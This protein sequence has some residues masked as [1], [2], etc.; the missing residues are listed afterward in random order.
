MEVIEIKEATEL[1]TESMQIRQNLRLSLSNTL[2][3]SGK[4]L[5]QTDFRADKESIRMLQR[6]LDLMTSTVGLDHPLTCDIQCFLK[7]VKSR[8]CSS[9][10]H[11]GYEKQPSF[12]RYKSASNSKRFLNLTSP[13]FHHATKFHRTTI[14]D[15]LNSSSQKEDVLDDFLRYS[16][17]LEH[18]TQ[19]TPL[20]K[21]KLQCDLDEDGVLCDQE[22]GNSE[23]G[24]YSRSVPVSP[25]LK[26]TGKRPASVTGCI[27]S[28]LASRPASICQESMSGPLSSLES[29]LPFN[30]PVSSSDRY[31]FLHKSAWYHV[32][33]RYPT[34]QTPRPPKRNQIRKDV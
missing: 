33:G 32:P 18:T 19:T 27:T 22:N 15:V 30:R 5:S 12:P 16:R 26:S 29:L 10:A 17:N 7:E 14:P 24:V 3:K 1:L 4:L 6:S 8:L 9:K 13:T 2:F 23:K 31:K 25:M 28:T 20:Q 34:L 21:N 11:F